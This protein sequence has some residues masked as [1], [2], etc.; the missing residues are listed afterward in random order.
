MSGIVVGLATAVLVLFVGGAAALVIAWRFA[1]S[2]C[3]P[4]RIPAKRTPAAFGLPFEDVAFASGRTVL[5]GWYVPAVVPGAPAVILAHAWSGNAGLM[6]PLARRL[7]ASGLGVLLYDARGH[8]A[9][10]G[11]GWV[12]IIALAA[13]LSAAVDLLAARPDVDPDAIGV[14]G[15][16]MGGASAIVAAGLDPRIRAVASIASFADS[17]GLTAAALSE[18]HLPRWPF[19]PIVRLLIE[20][21][22][23]RSMAWASPQARVADITVPL[24]L[25]Q[26]D[27]D[28]LVPSSDLETLYRRSGGRAVRILLAGRGHADVLRDARCGDALVRHFVRALP[29]R[30]AASGQRSAAG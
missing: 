27:A 4:R 21:A 24:L 15:H 29:V 5:R 9:S 3:R 12:T 25:I 22:L 23:G 6:L 28:R 7:H 20:R 17:V 18:H 2:W 1:G 26:G 10:D 16:S 8:G 30:G 11:G 14:A 13:D 19:L